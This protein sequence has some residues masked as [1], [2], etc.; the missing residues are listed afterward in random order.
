MNRMKGIGMIV[1]GAML[2]GATGPMMEWLLAE[3]PIE[4]APF[5]VIRLLIAGAALLFMLNRQGK[6]VTLVWRQKAWARQLVI[7]GVVGMLG[8]QFTFLKTIEASNAVIAT[9]L[10]FLAPI[11]VI[12]FVTYSQRKWPPVYQ[13]LGILVTLG[14]LVLLLTNGSLASL[15]VSNAAL[16]WGVTLGF[17][18]AFYTLFPAR[19]MHEFGVIQTVAWAMVI[20]GTVLLVAQ[21]LAVVRTFPKLLDPT[22]LIMMMLIIVFATAGFILLLGSTKFISPVETSVLSSFEP[23][24]AM[25][26]SMFWFGQILAKWQLGGALIML[27]GV[28]WLSVAGSKASKVEAEPPKVA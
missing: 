22:V 18:F 19:L 6:R 12:A 7:F 25:I 21:P 13:M 26:V 2:W 8:V 10:Q 14:G 3:K 24:T 17:T 11:F 16:A 15:Q 28:I 9:L 23:L 5:I 1:S 20:G 27:V 4:V